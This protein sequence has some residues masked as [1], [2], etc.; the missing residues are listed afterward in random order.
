MSQIFG[1]KEQVITKL[2]LVIHDT[3]ADIVAIHRFKIFNYQ[4]VKEERIDS[5]VIP[6]VMLDVMREG[7]EATPL[8][9]HMRYEI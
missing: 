1:P 7:F 5:L 6:A 3:S 9:I 4:W 8:G 2:N